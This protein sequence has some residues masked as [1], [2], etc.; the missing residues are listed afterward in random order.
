MGGMIASVLNE[1]KHEIGISERFWIAAD[2]ARSGFLSFQLIRKQPS[3]IHPLIT[4]ILVG[5]DPAF[6]VKVRQ[7]L[8]KVGFVIVDQVLAV[9]VRIIPSSG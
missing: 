7:E 1:C 8:A 9:H 3:L 6:R 2:Q 5:E 4:R